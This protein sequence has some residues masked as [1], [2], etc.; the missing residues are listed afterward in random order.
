MNIIPDKVSFITGASGD[1]EWPL[2]SI[3]W[4]VELRF[5]K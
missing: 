5:L 4:K 1:I 3:Y 2:V